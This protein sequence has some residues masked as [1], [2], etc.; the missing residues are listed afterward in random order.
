MAPARVGVIGAGVSGPAMAMFLQQKGYAPVLYERLDAPSDAGLGIGIQNNGQAVLRRIPGLLEHIAGYEADEFHFYSV[1]PEDTALLGVSDH[2][3]RLRAATGLG[4]MG[5]RR[6]ALHARLVEF[7]QRLGVPVKFGHKLE[8]LEDKGDS[9]EV[10]FANGVKETFDF[11]VGCDGLHSNTRACLFGETPADY[12]GLSQWG[13]LSPTPEFWKGKRAPADI[14][15]NGSHMILVPMS[16]DEMVWAISQREPEAKE[17]W[18]SIDQETADEFKKNSRFSEW[19]FGIGELVKSS[20]KIIRYGIYDRPELETWFKGRVILIGDAAHPTSPHLG[21]GANQA[22]EDVG[23]LIDLLEKHNPSAEA[24]SS[25]TL[26]TVFSE[27]VQV[28]LPRTAELVRQARKQGEMRVVSGVDACIKRNN[29]YRE[30]CADP[31]KL[32]ERFGI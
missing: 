2:P 18:R 25:E 23:L 13:G 26:T 28:R 17:D 16:D 10:A 22:Y 14:F 1:M 20:I 5:V 31:A 3:R 24:P 4:T 30:M 6:P 15:D 8:G 27:L 19:P 7:A 12:T 32:K 29:F 11:V 21:Q 9:V